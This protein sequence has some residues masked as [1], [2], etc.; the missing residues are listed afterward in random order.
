[1]DEQ[2]HR[3]VF[4]SHRFL[5]TKPNRTFGLSSFSTWMCCMSCCVKKGIDYLDQKTT[6]C[7]FLC[8][9]SFLI[10]ESS[11]ADRAKLLLITIKSA[12]RAQTSYNSKH[13]LL[14]FHFKS[15]KITNIEFNTVIKKTSLSVDDQPH[16]KV[17]PSHRFLLAKPNRTFGLSSFSTWMCCMSWCVKKGLITWIRKRLGVSLFAAF[18]F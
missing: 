16:H 5:L 12:R 13:S 14:V 4:P 7:Q 10:K 2:S 6:R 11:V 17:F 1:M 8:I 9:L 18:L 15:R 3:K